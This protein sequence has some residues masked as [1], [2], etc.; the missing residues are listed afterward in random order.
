MYGTKQ[1]FKPEKDTSTN[2]NMAGIRRVQGVFGALLYYACTV[3]NKLLVD[4]SDIV[5]YKSAATK[6][7]ASAIHQLLDCVSTYPKDGII[8]RASDMIMCAHYNLA[9]LNES[10]ASSQA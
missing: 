4:L 7:T 10:K 3:D 2:L 1:Q 8:Y 9:Y 5:A 6:C